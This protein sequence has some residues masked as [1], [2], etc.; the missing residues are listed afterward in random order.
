MAFGTSAT[1]ALLHGPALSPIDE[2]VY[3]D[4][5]HKLPDQ[6]PPRKGEPIGPE[7]LEHMACFGVTPYGPMGAPCA[8]SY[9]DYSVFPFGGITS[10]D[11]YTPLYFGVSIVVGE[12]FALLPGIDQLD[13]W[14]ISSAVWHS[15]SIIALVAL[16]RYWRVPAGPTVAV[17]LLAIGS[18]YAY[19]T[20]SYVSTDAPSF[21]FG[22]ALLLVASRLIRGEV[23]FLLL[24]VLSVL[25]TLFKVT[26]L[27]AVGLAALVVLIHFL[28]SL[29]RRIPSEARWWRDPVLLR[30][31]VGGMLASALALAAQALW[32]MWNRS[33]AVSELG[34]EQGISIPLTSNE[35]LGQLANFLPGTIV[36]NVAI[37]GSTGY[38]LPLPNF[39]TI[40]L[41]WMCVAGVVAALFL[42]KRDDETKPVI[43]AVAIASVTFAPALAIAFESLMG[44]YFPL[45][46]RYG[47]PILPGILLLAASI[48]RNRVGPSLVIP[49]GAALCVVMVIAAARLGS[50]V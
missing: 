22:A 29:K 11:A 10:A 46:P 38:A 34:A 42:M 23:G 5:L 28:F 21:L 1:T 19:W 32:L 8:G 33:T 24:V 47:A 12:A 4:Y 15:A 17:S 43:V 41:S 13:G 40:P 25:A 16:L 9:D 44:S 6:G 7:A 20:Y 3:I 18:P 2:W 45:P 14:R 31:L 26:N 39:V 48:M 30:P 49:Y 36:S 50:V 27:Y 35:V 37:A